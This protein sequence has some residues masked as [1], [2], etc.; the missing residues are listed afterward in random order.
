MY[1]KTK[2]KYYKKKNSNNFTN[3]LSPVIIIEKQNKIKISCGFFS[4][5][6]L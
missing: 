5:F 4:L 3:E 2:K 6:W 1:L